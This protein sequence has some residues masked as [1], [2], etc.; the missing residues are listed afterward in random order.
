VRGVVW[1]NPKEWLGS[2]PV[3]YGGSAEGGTA[4]GNEG[5][6]LGVHVSLFRFQDQEGWDKGCPTEGAGGE[7]RGDAELI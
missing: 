3:I 7:A 1:Q 5:G 6:G 4:A 2:A